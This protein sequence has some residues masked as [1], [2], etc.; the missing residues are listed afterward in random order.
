MPSEIYHFDYRFP[1]ILILGLHMGRNCRLTMRF[2]AHYNL[3]YN[4]NIV[5][6]QVLYENLAFD[7]MLIGITGIK[8][9][10]C[11]GV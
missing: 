10:L 4:A 6:F 8:D 2:V 11:D 7:L 9:S 5:I 3:L 1:W